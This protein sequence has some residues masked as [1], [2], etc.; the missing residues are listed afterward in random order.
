MLNNDDARG[1]LKVIER[2]ARRVALSRVSRK[3]WAYDHI[4]VLAAV[5]A[6]HDSLPESFRAVRWPS[7]EEHVN[8]VRQAEYRKGHN[9][10]TRP[11]DRGKTTS[12]MTIAT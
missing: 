3:V 6:S 12:R 10:T 2:L 9:R 7:I 8:E 1:A 5:P 11:A 4:D